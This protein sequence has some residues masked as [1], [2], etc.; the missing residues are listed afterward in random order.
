[1]ENIKNTATYYAYNAE[2]SLQYRRISDHHKYIQLPISGSVYIAQK[3]EVVD[4]KPRFAIHGYIL[5]MC[6]HSIAHLGDGLVRFS[7][8]GWLDI[9]GGSFELRQHFLPSGLD[10]FTFELPEEIIVDPANRVRPENW[11]SE[12]GPIADH[13]FYVMSLTLSAA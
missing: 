4:N 5:L 8:Y 13:E 10:P 3:P 1:M 12:I 7:P 9:G 6:T 2:G 11:I